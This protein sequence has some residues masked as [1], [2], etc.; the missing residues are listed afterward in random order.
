M[1]CLHRF[2]VCFFVLSGGLFW[3]VYM[4]SL[5]EF[6]F[7]NGFFDDLWYGWA[8]DGFY[9]WVVKLRYVF[10]N[11]RHLFTFLIICAANSR[12]VYFDLLDLHDAYRLNY[13]VYY[14]IEVFS[15]HGLICGRPMNV[16]LVTYIENDLFL[17]V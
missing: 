10:I 4:F 8:F 13:L 17:V 2:G 5:M 11:D 6:L 1:R 15:F 14:L 9:D 3:L 7:V 12:N 16:N